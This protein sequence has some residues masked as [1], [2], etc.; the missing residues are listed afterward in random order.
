M[1]VCLWAPEWEGADL[2][3]LV[4]PLANKAPRLA[5]GAG[6]IWADARGLDARVLTERV[7]AAAAEH[8]PQV[9]AGLAR[10]PIVAQVAARRTITEQ[11]IAFV[12]DDE[13][14]YLA[15]LPVTALG[16]DE[17]LRT[18]LQSV[19]IESCGELAALEREAVEVRFGPLLIQQWQW[20][21]AE[22]NRWLFRR[23]PADPPRASID[24]IDYVISDPERLI[25][26]VNALFG[27]ICDDLQTQG[28][29]ARRVKLTLSLGNG[30]RWERVLRPARPT[31]SRTVWL[32]M[33]RALIERITVSDAINGIALDVEGIEGASSVQGDLFDGG[34]ATASAVD[35]AV[36]RVLE[37]DDDI[38]V[39]P[40]VSAH[41]L[42][43]ERTTWSAP[44]L[45]G[46]GRNGSHEE[47]RG[48]TL[49][50]LPQPREVLV[51]TIRRRD[52]SVPIRFRDG[53]WKQLVTAAGPD[54]IS[55][56]R[57]EDQPYAR[58][59]FRGVTVDGLLVWIYRDAK[60]DRW[61]LHGWWD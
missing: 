13:R 21:R 50:L 17:S 27:G 35:A 61:F 4:E 20:A 7:H 49:Q 2:I 53:Q 47:V 38:L 5:L 46:N 52:H 60:E 10:A 22:D 57:W 26:S 18:L 9:R 8:T 48:L 14:A 25:F 36:A 56:G 30:E 42:P 43:E 55:G 37:S 41:P 16:I 12:P 51:E 19:G 23:P 28:Q 45:N 24:F 58:E 39:E 54:R 15:E 3:G 40:D 33:A 1:I 31:G 32:R 44:A 59:Y 11:K 6:V 34:F 29:H